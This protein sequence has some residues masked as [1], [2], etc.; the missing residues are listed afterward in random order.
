MNELNKVP[1]IIVNDG[2]CISTFCMETLNNLLNM[3]NINNEKLFNNYEIL[4]L[5]KKKKWI[6]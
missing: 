3:H 1:I 6:L 4:K 2:C 5:K